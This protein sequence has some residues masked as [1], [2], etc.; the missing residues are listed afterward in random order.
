MTTVNAVMDWL[1]T[2]RHAH[3]ALDDDADALLIRLLALDAQQQTHQLALNCRASIALFGHSQP[4]KAHLLRTLCGSGEGRLT[5]QS[6]SKTLDYF[7]HINPGHSLTQMAL[8]FSRD[9]STPDDAFPLR[10]KLMR[11]AELVQLFIA[12][13]WQRGDIR[14]PDSS[15]IAERLSGWQSLRQP[16]PVPG[17]TAT[18]IAAISRFWRDTLPGNYQQIDDALWYQF[19]HLLPS[20]DLSARARAWSLLWGEQQEL[21]QQWLTLAHT[22]HQLGNRR[23]VMAP[24]SLLVDAFTLPMDAF[25]TP[26]GNSD[27]AVLVHPLTRDGY[28]NAVSVPVA[29]LAQLTLE[30]V[31]ST[32]HGVLDNVDIIDI[33]VPPLTDETPLWSSKCRW[34]LDYYRQQQQ[35]DILL[36]CNATAQRSAIPSSAKTLLRWVN[37]TQPV[38]EN[39]LP[40]LVWAITPEDD[41]F[42]HKRHF[43]EAIQQLVGKPGQHWGTLQ[44]LD[45]S[46]LQRL[47]EWLSQASQPELRQRR[48]AAISHVRQQQLRTLCQPLLAPAQPDKARVETMIRELQTHAA[49]HGEL[50]ESLLPE[51]AAFDALCQVQQQREEKVSGLF[52]DAVDLFAAPEAIA[53]NP[54]THQDNGSQAYALWCKHL[55]QWSRQPHALLSSDTQQQ[56]ALSLLV[57]SQRLSLAQQLRR[58]SAEQQAGAAQ[59]RA[60]IGNFINWLGYAEQPV[61]QRPAS[62]IAKGSAIFVQPTAA[63]RT[64]LT[65]LGEQPVHAATRYVYDW[66]VALYARS[67]DPGDAVNLLALR[68]DAQQRLHALLK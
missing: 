26:G 48:F 25:L 15:V 64:R 29:T 50:L 66:L 3:P 13:A 55:R 51:L 60:I 35:P 9:Q 54:L 43:D 46:S 24:L 68:D 47:M 33:P 49:R 40:G 34:L 52:N 42:I 41:R 44:A 32:E 22:L 20:L 63:S 31:L 28:Q 6:G 1:A 45:H 27:D 2:E 16:Q 67:T 10:L 8:R 57:A 11:E 19:A 53:S 61:A 4:S 18:D 39:K 12:H 59:L 38:Q 7:S 17:L 56:L 30:L 23:E 62:R 36:A 37:E 65:Q 5:V 21:T 14:P 58:A